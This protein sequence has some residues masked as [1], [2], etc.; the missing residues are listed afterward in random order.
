MKALEAFFIGILLLLAAGILGA[1][2]PVRY[3]T[4]TESTYKGDLYSASGTSKSYT[5]S[6][7]PLAPMLLGVIGVIGIIGLVMLVGGALRM[8]QA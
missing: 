8:I 4:T 1:T 3:V 7:P 2:I 6:E 5:T